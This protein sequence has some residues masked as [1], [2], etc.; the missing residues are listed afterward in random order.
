M[1]CLAQIKAENKIAYL[2]GDYK[3]NL[4]NI[5]KHAAS[6]DL[7][8]ALFSHSL[9]PVVTKPTRVTNKSATLIDIIF[10]NNCVENSRSLAGILYTD[11]SDHFPVYH[12]DYSD[13]VPLTDNLFKKRIYSIANM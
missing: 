11:I 13:V 5:D 7:A 4:L 9:F 2:L 1:Q 6:Q 3:I 12:I 10:Y 8:D